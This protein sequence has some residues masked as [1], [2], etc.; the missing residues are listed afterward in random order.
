MNTRTNTQTFLTLKT[1]DSETLIALSINI[2]K[3][4]VKQTPLARADIF[5]LLS[6]VQST[7][8]TIKIFS[9]PSYKRN[10]KL[11]F[12]NLKPGTIWLK[13]EHNN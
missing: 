13:E 8:Q 4:V 7:V 5:K 3:I 12:E 1:G 2:S 9:L 10:K 6:F 11:I